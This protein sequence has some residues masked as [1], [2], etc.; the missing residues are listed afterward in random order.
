MLHRLPPEVA[1][2]VI[3]AYADALGRVFLFAAPVALVGFVLALTLKEVP[4]RDM[5]NAPVDLGE[6]FAMPSGEN[7]EEILEGAVGRMIRHSPDLRLRTLAG[8]PGCELDVGALWAL[9]QIYRNKQ[10]FGSARLTDIAGRLRVPCEVLEPTFGR[11]TATGYVLQT[12]DE[13]WLTQSGMRQVDAVSAAIV[14]RIHRKLDGAAG[15]QGR[16]DRVQ[17]EAALERIAH[18]LLVQREWDRDEMRANPEPAGQSSRVWT[19]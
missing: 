1:A 15:F 10:V 12:G 18:R 7:S 4:L 16:P 11:L 14:G 5:D 2:P 9:L 6:G 19:R 8:R 17:V 13:L 3:D